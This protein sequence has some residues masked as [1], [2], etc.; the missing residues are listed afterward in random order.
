[1]GHAWLH[2]CPSLCS[3]SNSVTAEI[4]NVLGIDY[5]LVAAPQAKAQVLDVMFKVRV[6][7]WELATGHRPV[8]ILGSPAP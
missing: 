3:C 6:K 7:E 8:S 1:M 5:S 2:L 4:D